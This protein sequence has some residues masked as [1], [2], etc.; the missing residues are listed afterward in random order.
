MPPIKVIDALLIGALN[1][2]RGPAEALVD[3]VH[4]VLKELVRKSIGECQELKQFPTL[5]TEI[6]VRA[7]KA[8]ESFREE[9]KK[10]IIRLV[11][12]ESS[13]LIVNFF[14][15]L[16]QEVEKG[17]N[18]ATLAVDRYAE[19]YFRRIG[20]NVLS[21]VTMVSKTLRNI[22]LKA[23]FYCQVKES[24]QSLLNHF[25]TQIGRK[26]GKQ[27]FHMLDEDPKLMEGRI[28]CAKRLELYKTARDEMDSVSWAR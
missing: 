17:G 10:T 26:K 3:A 6:A 7:N 9:S 2:F 27:L 24:K 11:D 28:Q 1:Y 23:V 15:R 20:S 4:F 8:L 14:Q 19:G 22:I 5:K 18:P 12:I 25:N 21:Y 16:P 13:Y